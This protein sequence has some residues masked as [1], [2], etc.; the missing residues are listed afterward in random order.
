MQL[1]LVFGRALTGDCEDAAQTVKAAPALDRSKPTLVQAAYTASLC[2]DRA[3]ALPLLAKLAKDYP[4]DTI[5]QQVV[6]PES[7]ADMALAAHRPADALHELD[8]GKAFYLVSAEAYFEGLACLDLQ[9]GPGAIEV[10]QR[11]ARYKGN[12]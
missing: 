3:D 4:E 8:G 9:N 2:D 11:A 7:H 12:G 5:T 10:F 1:N 6:L